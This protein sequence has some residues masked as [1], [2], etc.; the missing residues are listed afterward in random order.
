LGRCTVAQDL[1]L[2]DRNR[3]DRRQIRALRAACER[4]VAQ[5]NDGGAVP[6]LAVHQEQR[7]VGRQ[8]AQAEWP[9]K[10]GGV[11][12]AEPRNVQCHDLR[13]QHVRHVG[14]ARFGQSLTADDI[15]RRRRV[16]HGRAGAPGA[17]DNNLF[18]RFALGRGFLSVARSRDG[19]SQQTK[20]SSDP[21]TAALVRH[22]TPHKLPF[23]R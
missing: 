5:L 11:V 7:F 8:A 19:H 2:L 16:G 21:Q 6:T 13:A 4:L 22:R 20:S 17:S 12:A 14:E 3:R 10:G 23:Y 15:D 1:E 18:Q 9:D